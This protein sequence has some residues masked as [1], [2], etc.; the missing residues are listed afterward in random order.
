MLSLIHPN[1]MKV[2]LLF[3]WGLFCDLAL[4]QVNSLLLFDKKNSYGNYKL[5]LAFITIA[6][7]WI[8][9]AHNRVLSLIL[10][11]KSLIFYSTKGRLKDNRFACHII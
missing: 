8:L 9:I 6:F 2:I 10:E 7:Y 5:F 4:G 11:P 3:E 1:Q